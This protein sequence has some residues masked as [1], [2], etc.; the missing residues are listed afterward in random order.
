[1]FST[2]FVLQ[3]GHARGIAYLRNDDGKGGHRNHRLDVFQSCQ[4]HLQAALPAML[5]SRGRMAIKHPRILG[6]CKVRKPNPQTHK[7][8]YA[9]CNTPSLKL[10]QMSRAC[11]LLPSSDKV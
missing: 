9:E 4:E 8:Q 3:F 6:E 2:F 10:A 5:C 1:M 7:A 11:T